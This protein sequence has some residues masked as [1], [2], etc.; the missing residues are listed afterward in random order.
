MTEQTRSGLRELQRLDDAI[1]AIAQKIHDLDTR[2][3]EVEQPAQTLDDEVGTTRS[4]LQ[5]MR[6]EERRIEL[7]GDEK[8]NRVKKLEDRLGS[9]RNVREESAVTAELAMVRRAQEADEQEA[10]SLL[11]QIRRLEDRLGE[12]SGALEEAK[13]EVEPRRLELEAEGRA[14]TEEEARLRKEREA[15]AASLDEAELR[16]YDAIR[17]GTGRRALAS[18]TEDGACGFC[19]SVVPLQVQN[20]ILH[21]SRMIR[22]EACGVIL[23]APAEE[24]ETVSGGDTVDAEGAPEAEATEAPEASEGVEEESEGADSESDEETG[25]A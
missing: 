25:T 11:D 15:F 16:V 9:V 13:A 6:V 8:R 24:E 5:E 20:E 14:A 23:A 12:Q 21:G 4:R 19:F 10:L 2:L 3:E 7:A 22:C 18:L 17:G 1:Q